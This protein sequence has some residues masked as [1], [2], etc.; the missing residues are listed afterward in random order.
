LFLASR[1][2]EA[3]LALLSDTSLSLAEVAERTGRPYQ[4]VANKAHR[5]GIRRHQ[6]SD[7][8]W[9]D[10]E[11]VRNFKRQRYGKGS[12]LGYSRLEECSE[13]E[14][15]LLCD[16]SLSYVEI[17]EQ[18]G[19]SVRSAEYRAKRL[20]VQRLAD[21]EDWT[22]AELATLRDLS[23]SFSEV[24]T[25]TGRSWT[26]VKV[27]ANRLGLHCRRYWSQPGYEPGAD[28]YRGQGW[29]RIRLDILER[30]Q[31]TCRDGGEFVPSG[32]G[33][34]VHH[35]IPWRL[36]PVNDPRFLVTLCR[37]HHMKRPEHGWASI[38]PHVEALLATA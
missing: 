25:L 16:T 13:A 12:G 36:H 28:D 6:S 8:D 30:D 21:Y 19:W 4:G 35:E 31:Y 38:P 3:E 7:I 14:L 15:A 23:L 32:H 1:W 27:K 9:S 18:T 24:A 20:G 37:S 33:L 29:R 17:A 11:Q 2:T 26:A 22:E 34:V 10:P 5:L